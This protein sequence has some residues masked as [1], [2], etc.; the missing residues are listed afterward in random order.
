[1]TRTPARSAVAVDPAELA[2]LAAGRHADPH[3]ILGAHPV[4]EGVV[5]RALHPDA[6]GAE[7]LVEGGSE[8]AMQPLGVSGMFGVLLPGAAMPVRY[9]LRFR[10][11][12]GGT[13]EQED[14]YR[15]LPS[16]GDMDIY[17]ISEGTHRRLWQ[18]LG[19]RPRQ[20]DGVDGV[21]FAVWAPNAQGV[22]VI[23][24]FSRWDDRRLPMRMLG[25]SGV[26]ELFVPGVSAGALYKFR[27]IGPHGELRIKAD[28][29]ARAMELFLVRIS[30]E[31]WRF[32]KTC[33]TMSPFPSSGGQLVPGA[34]GSLR[35]VPVPVV[36]WVTY[37][38]CIQGVGGHRPCPRGGRTAHHPAKGWTSRSR[39]ALPRRA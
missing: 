35:L 30:R 22:S 21:S 18:S 26:Y 3:R 2:K 14:P 36:V 29:F 10:F 19:A 17:L 37:A 6:T 25:G 4:K 7:C 31:V 5:V 28:P 1:M 20:L 33:G 13:W 24:D 27:I 38:Y 34:T 15:F 8:V 11:A 9:R 16:L 23:G 39:Q 32:C 12:G